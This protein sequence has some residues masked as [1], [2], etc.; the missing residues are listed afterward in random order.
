MKTIDLLRRGI[1]GEKNKYFNFFLSQ[2][3]FI[4]IV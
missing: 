2:P 4:A 3:R 1:V